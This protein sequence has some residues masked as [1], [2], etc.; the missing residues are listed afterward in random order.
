MRSE[1]ESGADSAR[2]QTPRQTYSTA[3]STRIT[4]YTVHTRIAVESETEAA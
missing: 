1:K 4:R 2:S 3:H